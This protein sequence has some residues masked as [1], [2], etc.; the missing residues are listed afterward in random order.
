M[1]SSD[2]QLATGIY[3]PLPGQ[4]LIDKQQAYALKD[5]EM[6]GIVFWCMSGRGKNAVDKKNAP[7]RNKFPNTRCRRGR[8]MNAFA[9][10]NSSIGLCSSRG[11]PSATASSSLLALT[12]SGTHSPPGMPAPNTCGS[13]SSM[14]A[15]Q[16]VLGS[17]E[18]AWVADTTPR[19]TSAGFYPQ[20]Q[21]SDIRCPSFGLY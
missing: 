1:D 4:F 18:L 21:N 3:G 12:N 6:S 16:I 9:C 14:R 20:D 8:N 10:T 13:Q 17:R 5:N 7:L 19:A 11:I 15:T 2:M